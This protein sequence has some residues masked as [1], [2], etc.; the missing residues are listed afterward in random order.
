MIQTP[1]GQFA[2]IIKAATAHGVDRHTMSKR[3][4]TDPE[5]YYKVEAVYK[6]LVS[7]SQYR[8]LPFDA[9]EAI[10]AEWCHKNRL[11]PDLAETAEAFFDT[12]CAITEDSITVDDPVEE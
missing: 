3:L 10:Y 8:V 6:K 9:K 11:D 7:W 4:K 1:L 2:S 5:N 12:I